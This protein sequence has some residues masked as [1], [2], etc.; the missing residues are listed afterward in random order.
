MTNIYDKIQ[1]ALE[2]VR[3][4][5]NFEPEIGIVLGTGLGNLAKEIKV[6]LSIPYLEIP[7]FPVSTVESHTHIAKVQ[8]SL[9][10]YLAIN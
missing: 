4:K 1:E 8:L 6:E 10:E 7:H 3:S 2:Y 9:E 5:S